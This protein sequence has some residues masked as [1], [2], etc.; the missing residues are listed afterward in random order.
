MRI[1]LRED[2]DEAYYQKQRANNQVRK[3]SALPAKKEWK[4]WRLVKNDYP[5]TRAFDRHDMLV[6]KRR[7]PQPSFIEYG[8]L[9]I[10]LDELQFSYDCHMYNFPHLQSVNN[11]F[12]IHLLGYR[13]E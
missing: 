12:H 1:T 5:Y 8:E 4:Y 2:D 10:I 3:L 9:Q 11:H 7:H 6:L 13:N